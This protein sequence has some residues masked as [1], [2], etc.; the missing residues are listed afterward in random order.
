MSH[1]NL[2]AKSES[3]L[4]MSLNNNHANVTFACKKYR[5]SEYNMNPKF[6]LFMNPN[7][8]STNGNTLSAARCHMLYSKLNFNPYAET[9]IPPTN[10]SKLNHNAIHF[11]PIE[12][13]CTECTDDNYTCYSEPNIFNG[14]VSSNCI[15]L[16]WTPFSSNFSYQSLNPYAKIFVSVHI[17]NRDNYR[18]GAI[19]ATSLILSAFIFRFLIID[20][21]QITAGIVP[22]DLLSTL[23][24]RNP[25]KIMIG[26]LNI[27]S[28]R[29][30]FECLKDI[31]GENI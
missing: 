1:D 10:I 12:T 29:N 9:F 24:L 25:N 6:P 31:I 28:I 4:D 19:I 15:T 20:D 11:V 13:I 30:K 8:N 21:N 14:F 23:K 7:L 26:H 18:V 22:R 16:P 27:N 3:E 5:F 17:P 2:N